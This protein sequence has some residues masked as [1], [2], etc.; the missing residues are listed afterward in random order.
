MTIGADDVRRLLAS[1]EDAALVV[2][3]GRAAVVTPEEL[4]S[5]EYRGALQIATRQELVQR[6]GRTE[7]S[8]REL[9][10]QAEDLDTAVRNLGG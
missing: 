4:N 1:Q 6:I 10:E 9:A 3:E 7:L 2:V 5:A 8:D